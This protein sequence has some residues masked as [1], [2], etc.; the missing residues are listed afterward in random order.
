MKERT[1]KGYIS[2]I[3]SFVEKIIADEN[4]ANT[5][6]VKNDRVDDVYWNQD[7]FREIP[8]DWL[9]KELECIVDLN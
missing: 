6:L 1:G 4:F 5:A 9:Q 3:Q 7:V 8:T 2:I